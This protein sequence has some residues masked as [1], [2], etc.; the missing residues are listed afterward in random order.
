MKTIIQKVKID[1]PNGHVLRGTLRFELEY[2]TKQV[3]DILL[4]NQKD[5]EATGGKCRGEISA[6]LTVFADA[7][8]A[9]MSNVDVALIHH[10]THDDVDIKSVSV[11]DGGHKEGDQ[12]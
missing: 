2:M 10:S 5:A 7:M 3:Q 8:K 12:S 4:K 9:D 1:Y 6:M 11:N